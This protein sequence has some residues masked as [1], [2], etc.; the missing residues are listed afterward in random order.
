MVTKKKLTQW[1]LR[2]T[3]YADR[4]LDDMSLLEGQW[5]DKVLHM[6]RN[7][8]GRSTGAEVQFA[9]E[10]RDEPVTVYTTRPDTLFGATFFVVAADSD[11]AAELAA[12]TA[13]EAEF[14]EYLVAHEAASPTSTGWPRDRPKTGVFLHR[15]AINP[16]N[17]ERLPIY[18]SDYVLADY[19]TGAIMAVPAHDQRDL[20]FARAFDLPV[21]VVV[22]GRHRP[23]GDRR[24]DRRRRRARQL[25]SAG[26]PGQGRGDRPDD[27]VARPSRAA[28]RPRS[29]TACA[30]G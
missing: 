22:D 27:R 9:I 30:T 24:G 8:I 19:G 10:G 11:L 23:A 7:W 26:R 18:A 20:D 3:D 13:A 16:V 4:L 14:A 25:R 2:I 17:D 6:Q 28:G 1:Y 5:P 21:R 29:T 15:Y 12:G